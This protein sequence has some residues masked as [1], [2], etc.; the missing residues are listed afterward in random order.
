MDSMTSTRTASNPMAL[1][2]RFFTDDDFDYNARAALGKASQGVFDLGTAASTLH[3]I[4]DGDPGSWLREWTL[5][6]DRMARN[7]QAAERTGRDH[8]AGYY[9]LGAAE[10]YAR[11]IAFIDALPDDRDLLPTFRKHRSSWDSFVRMSHG[12]HVQVDVP[13]GNTAMPGYLFRPDRSGLPRPTW[14]IT[15][16]SDGSLSGLWAEGIRA[17]LE[18]G[19]NV[20]VFDGPGQQSMLFEKGIP[21]RHDWENALTP[22]VDTLVS[23]PDVDATRLLA[24]ALSQGGYW[25]PRGLAFEHRFVA[26]VVDDGVWD[27]SRIWYS[28]LPSAVMELFRSHDRDGF[29]RA[30]EQASTD[31]VQRR[32]FRFRARPYG[33]FDTPYD[34]FR[35]VGKYRL[36]DVVGQIDTPTLV[37]DPDDETWFTGQPR[38]L[39]DA[40]RCEKKLLRLS[41]EDGANLHCEPWA[42]DRVALDTCDFFQHH[43]NAIGR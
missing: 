29:N 2:G 41:R 30:L 11:A 36:A 15:N 18:R 19:W 40:L 8:T 17:G 16:G 38:E 9:H 21:F 32:G 14:V 35:E 22:V 28:H 25:L 20:F 5:T 7:A 6:A 37:C 4:V 26:A 13:Y 31:P 39:Y 10:A 24:S 3:R 43:L 34:L 42:R 33:A 1:H 27:V 23:R 12:R